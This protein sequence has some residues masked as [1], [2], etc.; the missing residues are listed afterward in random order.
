MTLIKFSGSIDITRTAYFGILAIGNM[1]NLILYSFLAWELDPMHI[2]I[3]FAIILFTGFIFFPH[4]I[5]HNLVVVL[6][7]RLSTS[8]RILY[9]Y[10]G[11]LSFLLTLTY[12]LLLANAIGLNMKMY[13]WIYSIVYAICS[14]L[15]TLRASMDYNKREKP[16]LKVYSDAQILDKIDSV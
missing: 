13:A 11:S 12:S 2:L 8:A 7:Y 5:L 3:Y 14:C 10:L 16:K 6:S 15:F 4:F 9:L 1:L